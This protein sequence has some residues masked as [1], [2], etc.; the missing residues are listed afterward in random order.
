MSF[1]PLNS[2]F[3]EIVTLCV[4]FISLVVPVPVVT[5]T[6]VFEYAHGLFVRIHN[7]HGSLYWQ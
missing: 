5:V 6:T 1:V 2:Q 7:P 3:G 4:E